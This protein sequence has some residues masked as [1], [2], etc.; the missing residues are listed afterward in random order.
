[1]SKP[2]FA[3]PPWDSGMLGTAVFADDGSIVVRTDTD[4]RTNM[5]HHEA[6]INLI[7]AAPDLYA[8][9]NEM[10]VDADAHAERITRIFGEDIIIPES[11]E[12]FARAK[13]ALAK[14]RGEETR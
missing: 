13:A 3:P 11:R 12:M 6:N 7:V 1:M 2:R 8:A 14:A 9:L 5:K 10:M 4:Y